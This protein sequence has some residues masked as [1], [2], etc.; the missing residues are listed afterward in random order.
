MLDLRSL[1][2]EIASTSPSGTS[3]EVRFQEN[4]SIRIS[5]L[6]GQLMMNSQD[7]SRGV[8]ARAFAGG[9]WGFSSQSVA[10]LET[11]RKA[12]R[13]ARRNASFLQQRAPRNGGLIGVS[14]TSSD[15]LYASR[16]NPVPSGVWIELVKSVDAL[17][18]KRYPDLKARSV[19]LMS[20]HM[21]KQ[22]VTSSDG[23]LSSM[24]PRSHLFVAMTKDSPH[25]PIQH[26][27][28]RG[29]L[30][31]LQDLFLIRPDSL[32]GWLD[33]IYARTSRKAEGILPEAGMHDVILDSD[34]AGVLAHEAVGHTA[35]A[36]LVLGGS[37]AG[38][39]LGNVV[40]SP[41]V[42]LVDFAH[43]YRGTVCPQP[44]H[45]DDEGV[46]ATDT[47]IIDKGVLKTFMHN[48]ETAEHFKHKATGHAR[49]FTFAD[50]PLIRMR[51]TA[52]LPGKSKLEEMI[53]SI[54]NGYYLM[55]SGNG[56]ADTTGEFM[57]ATGT[58]YE[59]K[60]GKLGR[61]LR[62]STISGVA[63]DMLRSVSMISDEFTW[64]SAGY[65]GKK[66]PMPVGMGGPSIKA[67]VHVG[68]R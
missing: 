17:I 66:Q 42:S 37:V 14:Q 43:T 9:Y 13:D 19:T 64:E 28:I 36:D 4:K 55:K 23:F 21:R 26:R 56:Q 2:P 6:N 12:L 57:F 41:L 25:G 39:N 45:V 8:S 60:N 31:E 63:F 29:G 16:V 20:L 52:I 68:G 11:A 47:V 5:M 24:V 51:N 18:A 61:A 49:A 38:D 46:A 58:G 22:I 35:E 15:K 44:V 10:S 1:K 67:R 50:E 27:E 40:A 54:D 62:D 59:I 7:V 32:E 48:R 3:C 30:G 65:C 34:L 53:A 33:E